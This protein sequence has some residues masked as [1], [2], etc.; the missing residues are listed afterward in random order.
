VA[1][2]PA[3]FRALQPEDRRAP[4]WARGVAYPDLN[5]MIVQATPGADPRA[6]LRH[7]LSHLAVGRLARERVPRWFLEGLATV[8][9]GDLWRAYGPAL[10][11][12]AVTGT[13][14]SLDAMIEGFPP[15][16]PSAELAYA[17]SAAFVSNL[18]QRDG[19]SRLDALTRR[20]VSGERFEPAF[21]ATYGASTRQLERAFAERLLRSE[22]WLRILT[23][24]DLLWGA[25]AMLFL[26]A[27][28]RVRR[29]KRL[30]IEAMGIEEDLASAEAQAAAA[31]EA[32]EPG[33]PPAEGGPGEGPPPGRLLH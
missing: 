17:M 11:R 32:D 16:G 26:Y 30:R 8:Q 24:P 15:D 20:L 22:A 23:S 28:Y 14:P 27:W 2:D 29:R 10:D 31:D 5:L 25:M 21:Y 3:A 6:T 18:L 12:A 1:A 13:L 4:I 9:S 33:P 19:A 7:E